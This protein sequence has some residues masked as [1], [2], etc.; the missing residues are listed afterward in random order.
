VKPKQLAMFRRPPQIRASFGFSGE[1]VVDNFAGGGGAS[2]GIE[3]AIG[4]PVDIAINHDADAIAM[5]AVNH[6]RT[7][8]YQEDIWAVD[9]REACG[10]RPVGLAWFSPDCTHFSRAKGT[11]PVKK[12]IRGLAW[13]VIRWAKTVRPRVI[14]LENV[15]EFQTW[16]PLKDGRPD[17]G[18]AGRTFRQWL[19]KLRGLGYSIEFRTLVAADY[20]APTTRKRL[21]LI[22]RRDNGALVWPEA[23]HGKGR[24]LD[25]R[26]AA[27]II[28]W[29]LPCPSIFDRDRPLA[30]ATMRRIAEGMRRYVLETDDPYIVPVG[31]S[32]GVPTLIA[33]GWGE[34]PGQTPR[35]PGLEKPIGTLVAGGVKHA[36]VSAFLTK[37]YGG[38]VGHQVTRTIGTI[39]AKDHHALTTALLTQDADPKRVRQVRAFLTKF[40]GAARGQNQDVRSPLHTILSKARFGLVT[41]AG[42][43]YQ[44]AD[45][46]MRML[47]PHELFAAQGFPDD[48]VFDATAEGEPLTKTAQIRLAGN[49]VC[50][51]VA[52]AIVA[53]QV[54]QRAA[55]AA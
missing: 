39:T 3:A 28:D 51:P 40:Y 21:Y 15:E 52:E 16:G 43:E 11:K 12:E 42:E 8:H 32:A 54:Q 29:T 36:L 14:V 23:T 33:Q 22:A 34:R 37:H 31:G 19:G 9:P 27:E 55:V 6:P 17:P 30:Q 13:V 10:K 53:A 35:V 50:P 41:V 38:M 1:L 47:Q 26:P 25:W 24:E 5:H 45:I 7:K 4:R 49:S 20:G 44:I 48:Y 46:G 2:T 18:H